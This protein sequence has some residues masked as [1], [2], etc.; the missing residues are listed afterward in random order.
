[1]VAKATRDF[2]LKRPGRLLRIMRD[3]PRKSQIPFLAF[4]WANRAFMPKAIKF[5]RTLS[6]GYA[7][8]MQRR[9]RRFTGDARNYDFTVNRN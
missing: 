6:R 5:E 3:L 9:F 4:L 1:M 2:Y 8:N 7:A